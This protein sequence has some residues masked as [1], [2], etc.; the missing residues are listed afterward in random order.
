MTKDTSLL[1]GTF[2]FNYGLIIRRRMD[3]LYKLKPLY[4]QIKTSQE[5]KCSFRSRHLSQ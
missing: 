3:R 5:N 2:P 4:E 1:H